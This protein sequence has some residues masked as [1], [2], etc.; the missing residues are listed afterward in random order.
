MAKALKLPPALKTRITKLFKQGVLLPEIK[1]EIELKFPKINIPRIKTVLK[2]HFMDHCDTLW[3][4]AVKLKA[5]NICIVDKK[6]CSLN[7]HHMIGRGNYKY[8]WDVDN[9]LCLGVYRHTMAHDMSAHGSTSATQ[10]FA[11]WMEEN[12]SDR[13]QWFQGHRYDH[14]LI[15][16]DVYFLLETAK[17]LEAEIKELKSKPKVNIME[18][19]KVTE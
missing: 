19:K 9:G 7:A 1:A 18:R 4:E 2:A 13:W 11:D 5:G 6:P 16:V 12:A 10:A 3:S 17:R 8:R 14:E 15:K